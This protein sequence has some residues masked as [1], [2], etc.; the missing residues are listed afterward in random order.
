MYGEAREHKRLQNLHRQ[1][2]RQ[3]MA[4]LREFCAAYGIAVDD[5]RAEAVRH[6]PGTEKVS[7][8]AS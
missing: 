4:A 3:R 1:A 2:A 8:R 7:Q 5:I 6:G